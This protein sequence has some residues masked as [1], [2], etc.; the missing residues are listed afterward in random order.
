MENNRSSKV[1]AIVGL[2]AGIVGISLGFAAFSN[3]LTIKSS[4]AVTPDVTTFDVNLSATAAST[5]T[6]AV[7]GVLN[8]TPESGTYEATNFHADS[9]TIYNDAATGNA[10]SNA[11]IEGLKAYFTKPGQTVTYKFYARN[12][13]QYIAYLNGVTL[14][15]TG[16]CSSTDANITE[17]L[18]NTACAAIN[19][20]IS[21]GGTE[22]AQTGAITGGTEFT[23]AKAD[24]TAGYTTGH[25]LAVGASEPIVVTITYPAGGTADVNRVDG[26]FSVSFSDIVLTYGS[27]D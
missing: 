3:T 12:D 14:N 2:I 6:T 22:D 11:R 7:A 19:I 21:V 5:T 16:T 1:I 10:S 13:G 24:K 4:A 26:A 17:S 27:V 9:A 15:A 18:M 23:E 8:P 20:K 25:S